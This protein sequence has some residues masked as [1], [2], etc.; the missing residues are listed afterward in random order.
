MNSLN[1]KFVVLKGMEGFGDRLQCLLQAITYAQKTKRILVVDWSDKDWTHDKKINSDFYFRFKNLLF[2]PYET[3][4][5]YFLSNFNILSVYPEIWKDYLLDPN[6]EKFI[7]K[8]IF[9]V[10][11][12]SKEANIFWKIAHWD[13]VDFKEDV[14]VMP[15]INWRE[16]YYTS[17]GEIVFNKWITDKMNEY[18]ISNSLIPKKYDVIHLR[19]GS[20]TWAGGYNGNNKGYADKVKTKFP[21]LKTYLEFIHNDFDKKKNSLESK[22]DNNSEKLPLYLISDSSWLIEEWIKKFK[23]GLNLKNITSDG[24]FFGKS[25]THKL[26]K[27]ELEDI[28]FNKVDINYEVIL[29]FHIILNA[30]LVG[31]DG[32][33][34][35]S[36]L[37]DYIGKVE[38]AYFNFKT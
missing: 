26:S 13:Q 37:A 12:T 25:G 30:R 3:F 1:L 32:I 14:V 27:K 21:D 9:H 11:G 16:F 6:Y 19:A 20:K 7:W 31:H 36:S 24:K 4:Q 5:E 38:N 2:F 35:F 23:I 28:K 33:S 10:P 18:A 8:K 22:I 34:I 15:G 29:D 17:F